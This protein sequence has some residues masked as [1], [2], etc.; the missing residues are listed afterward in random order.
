[1]LSAGLVAGIGS[2]GGEASAAPR[3]SGPVCGSSKTLKTP[4]ATWTC[5]F[6]DE[7]NG[8]SVD[9]SKWVAQTTAGSGWTT[10]DTC[11]V[12]SPN[13]ISESNGALHLT[14]YTASTATQCGSGYS[15]NHLGGA[16]MSYNRFAQ[17]YGRFEIR[18]RFPSTSQAG[19]WGD[20]WLYPQSLTYGGWP[21]SGEIDIAE[22]WTG[23]SPYV[24]SSLHY[25]GS[26]NADSK[27]C[28]VTDPSQFH[29]YRVE[30]GQS[31]MSFYYDDALCFTRSWTATTGSTAPFDKPFFVM[32]SEGFGDPTQTLSSLLPS[33][34][35]VDVDYVRV[36]R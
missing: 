4:T 36:Y 9:A 27:A 5:T 3:P 33:S 7:F 21:A 23:H 32:L 11:Y 30:W 10:G 31:S 15:T 12:N 18:A 28:T 13:T 22:Y 24:M 29:T 35:P 34:G 19:F 16:V 6:D 14:A 1:V 8:T 20:L 25:S 17:T 26:T 2:P